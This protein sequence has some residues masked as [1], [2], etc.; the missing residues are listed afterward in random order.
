MEKKNEVDL[1]LATSLRLNIH[2]IHVKPNK[3][4]ANKKVVPLLLLHG[5]PG[6]VREFFDFIGLLQNQRSD[7]N[8]AFDII[9]PSLPGYGFS[10]GSSKINF[11]VFEMSVVLR[12]LMIRLG[13]DKFYAQGGDWGSAL[14]SSIATLFPQNV[15]G[16]HSN[17]CFILGSAIGMLKATIAATFPSFFVEKEYE[18]FHYPY[19]EKLYDFILETGYMHLQATKPDTIGKNRRLSVSLR[20][21]VDNNFYAF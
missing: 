21:S 10:Q 9:V 3:S 13:Y 19:G 2:Y 14:G 15:I 8:V 20:S 17:L 6:S 16:Y 12:N 7:L 1:L 18:D 11:G 5:W 4:A